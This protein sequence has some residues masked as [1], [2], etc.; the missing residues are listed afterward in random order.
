MDLDKYYCIISLE[1]Y[2]ITDKYLKNSKGKNP[3]KTRL[4]DYCDL[5]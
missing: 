1:L 4:I 2:F 3:P 5:V